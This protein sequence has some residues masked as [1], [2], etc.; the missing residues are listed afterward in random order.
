MDRDPAGRGKIG[1]N[2][3][4]WVDMV[5]LCKSHLQDPTPG[6]LLGREMGVDCHPQAV[7][8]QTQHPA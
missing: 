2:W 5:S 3:E 6:G 8:S 1:K 7:K 4:G